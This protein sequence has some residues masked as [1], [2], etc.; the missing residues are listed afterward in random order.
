MSMK[1]RLQGAAVFS[2]SEGFF[3]RSFVLG[4]YSEELFLGI[5]I[6]GEKM[7]CDHEGMEEPLKQGLLDSKTASFNLQFYY[8]KKLFTFPFS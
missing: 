1:Y 3:Q 7:F 6:H 5:C 2:L 4:A 8:T